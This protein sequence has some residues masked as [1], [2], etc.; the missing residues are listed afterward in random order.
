M[1]FKGLI[2][3]CTLCAS[4]VRCVL[5][6]PVKNGWDLLRV[7]MFCVV[8]PVPQVHDEFNFPPKPPVHMG[9]ILRNSL[10]SPPLP[11]RPSDADRPPALEQVLRHIN[12]TS[13]TPEELE[14][15][16]DVRG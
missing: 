16:L 10:P 8:P 3:R 4:I 6:A 14:E 7:P 5:A 1:F 11:L 13:V 9:D 15:S 2:Q 12:A